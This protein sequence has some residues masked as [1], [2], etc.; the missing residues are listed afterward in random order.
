MAVKVVLVASINGKEKQK[1]FYLS[2]VGL[3]KEL[4]HDVFYEHIL[5]ESPESLSQSLEKNIKFHKNIIQKIRKTDLVLS[6]TTHESISVGYLIHEALTLNKPVIAV[7]RSDTTPN[8]SVFLENFRKFTFF[9][10]KKIEEL[11]KELPQLINSTKIE[12]LKRFNFLISEK[13]DEKLKKLANNN[14]TSKSELLRTLIK[15]L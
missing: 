15:N 8:I 14:N 10:Y 1:F 2:I 3:L 5:K 6:E 4:G 11:K 12:K 9:P 13:I 7:S